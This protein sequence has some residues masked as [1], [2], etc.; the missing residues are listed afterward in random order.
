M[1]KFTGGM[2][3]GAACDLLAADV[4]INW[5]RRSTLK[6]EYS[7]PLRESGLRLYMRYYAPNWLVAGS[8]AFR[9]FHSGL[10]IAW[11]VLMI[12]ASIFS[13]LL[14]SPQARRT[15]LYSLL[16]KTIQKNLHWDLNNNGVNDNEEVCRP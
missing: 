5:A 16:P 8:L 3:S 7:A 6:A 1:T 13:L 4:T 9:P 14:E 11:I 10:W 2:C 12:G 15:Y